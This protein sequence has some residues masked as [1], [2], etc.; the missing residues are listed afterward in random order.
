M[1][2]ETLSP[3]IVSF[4]LA[5]RAIRQTETLGCFGQ[6]EE[7]CKYYFGCKSCVICRKM[8][9]EYGIEWIDALLKDYPL[10]GKR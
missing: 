3:E 4:L 2:T 9:T 7:S 8:C 5:L 6:Y 10:G 1:S